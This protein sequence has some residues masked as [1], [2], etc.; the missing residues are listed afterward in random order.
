MAKKISE[1][2]PTQLIKVLLI[3][4]NKNYSETVAELLSKEK[5]QVHTLT[6]G[7]DAIT[8]LNSEEPDIIIV[9]IMLGDKMSGFD[10]ITF[11]KNSRKYNHI[12]VIFISA[13]AHE[14]KIEE[15]LS[16]GANDYLTKPFRITQLA[17]KIKNLT[18]LKDSITRKHA[19][20]HIIEE[21]NNLD[22]DYKLSLDFAAIVN[23]IVNNSVDMTVTDIV[24]KLETNFTKLDI[25]IKKYYHQR[26]V[27]YILAKRLQ[28]ADLMLRNSNININ[29]VAYQCGFNSTSYFCT[30]FKKHFGK[31]P[32]KVRK[33][34]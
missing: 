7:E 34:D 19:N 28:R 22:K 17:L 29:T 32:L 20:Q 6:S 4:D 1:K 9:D 26:P 16:L 8:Y 31:S 14:S 11:L 10:F 15:G 21:V 18:K 27:N 2:K 13:L 23:E 24:D 33:E 5:L 12:P 30:A 3:E 25:V